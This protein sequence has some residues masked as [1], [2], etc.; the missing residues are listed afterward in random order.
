[1]AKAIGRAEK[2]VKALIYSRYKYK[3]ELMPERGKNNRAYY[4]LAGFS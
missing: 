4:R 1:M 3:C 2:T